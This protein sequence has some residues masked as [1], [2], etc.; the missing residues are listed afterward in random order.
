MFLSCPKFTHI[1]VSLLPGLHAM[2]MLKIILTLA[3]IRNEMLVVIGTNSM[4]YIVAPLPQVHISIYVCEAASPFCTICCPFTF[5]NCSIRPSLHTSSM[6]QIAD[7][8]SKVRCSALK[9]KQ[10]SLFNS[11]ALS[12]WQQTELIQVL[13]KYVC[14]A[15]E[16]RAEQR[17]RSASTG[18]WNSTLLFALSHCCNPDRMQ[19]CVEQS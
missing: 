15:T 19:V 8:L 9:P 3:R 17:W 6:P 4:C 7:P 14:H 2:P 13:V 11:I 10:R 16:P 1:A 12:S 5:K 18:Y